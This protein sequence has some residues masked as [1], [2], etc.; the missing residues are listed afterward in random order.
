MSVRAHDL[1]RPPSPAPLDRWPKPPKGFSG[2]ERDAWTRLGDAALELGTVSRADLLFCARVAQVS[3]RVDEAL[4]DREFKP[5]A[6]N[7]L[8]RLEAD[9][10][11]QIGLSPQARRAVTPLPAASDGESGFE[12][13]E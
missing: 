10:L 12:D 7:A 11:K 6:L 8:L 5:T 2:L 13:V 9:L 4:A 3:A 1:A